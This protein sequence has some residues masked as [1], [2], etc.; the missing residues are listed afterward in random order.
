L[1]STRPTPSA[2]STQTADFDGDCSLETLITEQGGA[3]LES[4][5]PTRGFTPVRG[6]GFSGRNLP[7]GDLDE[8]G[9]P[10]VLNCPS[11]NAFCYVELYRE[12]FAYERHYVGTPSVQSTAIG[13]LNGDRLPD[14]VIAHRNPGIISVMLN[15]SY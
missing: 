6:L 13:D 9:F 12:G 14:A 10:D 3:V 1:A 4:F 7:L 15:R 11:G 8:D 2:G 5:D